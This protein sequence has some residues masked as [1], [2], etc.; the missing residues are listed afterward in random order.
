MTITGIQIFLIHYFF[1]K[2]VQNKSLSNKLLAHLLTIVHLHLHLIYYVLQ[3]EN[4]IIVITHKQ[5]RVKLCDK[6]LP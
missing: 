2:T 5:I 3:Y 1:K 4:T 6:L